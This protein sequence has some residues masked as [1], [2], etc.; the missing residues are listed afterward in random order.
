MTWNCHMDDPAKGRYGIILGIDIW[1]ALG[2]NKKGYEHV[3]ESDYRPLKVLMA[4]VVHMCI[5]E[6]KILDIE[7]IRCK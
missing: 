6:I 1:T 3:I 4:P 2:L 7:T 5:Y